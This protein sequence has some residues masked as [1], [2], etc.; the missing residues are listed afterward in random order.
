MVRAWTDTVWPVVAGVVAAV[1][2][3]EVGRLVGPLAVLL[4]VVGLWLFIATV[5][6][7]AA[8]ESGLRLRAASRIGLLSSVSVVALL[9][10][11][12]LAPAAGWFVAL[13]VGVTSPA[14]LDR[15]APQLRSVTRWTSRR[16][17]SSPPDQAAI[18]QTF[19]EIV[20][21][22]KRDTA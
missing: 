14:L 22:W 6:Y 17:P 8:S 1:G 2:L 4:I 21:D 15:L 20:S 9:G 3:V 11:T 18:D 19:Q 13:G 12:N 5:T 10:I 16:S 7:G